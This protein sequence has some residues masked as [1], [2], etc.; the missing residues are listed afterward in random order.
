[1]SERAKENDKRMVII[2]YVNIP[3]KIFETI[4]NFQACL[5]MASLGGY[6]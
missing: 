1:M 4:K 3:I 6:I 2:L 5:T